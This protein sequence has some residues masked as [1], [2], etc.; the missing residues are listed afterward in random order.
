M[1]YLHQGLFCQRNKRIKLLPGTRNNAI[2]GEWLFKGNFS[3][4]S[5][6]AFNPDYKLTVGD[7]ILLQLWGAADFQGEVTIDAHGNI[8]IPKVGPVKVQGVNNGDLNMV[9]KKAVKRVYKA[10]VEVYANLITSQKIK[11]FVSG[12]VEN[13]GLYEGH[14]ADSL[15]RFIDQAGGI[16]KD[17]GSYRN[18]EL[19]RHGKLINQVDLY[20][21]LNQGNLPYNQLQDGDVIFVHPKQAE[22]TIDGEVGFTGRYELAPNSEETEQLADILRVLSLKENATHVTV[23]YQKGS[24]ANA[25]QYAIQQLNEIAVIPG[26]SIKVSSQLKANSISVSVLGEHNSQTEMVIPWG[27]TL[28]ELLAQ[29]EYTSLSDKTAIQLFRKSVADRQKAML[30]KSLNALEQTVLTARSQTNEAA[31]LRAKEAETILSWITKARDIAP[32]GQV[33]LNDGNSNAT[34]IY[35]KQGDKIVIPAKRNLVM[36]HGEVLFPTAIAYQQNI[37][38]EQLIEQAGGALKEEDEINVII[39]HPN[40]RVINVNEKLGEKG[41]ITA[42]DEVFVLTKPD[43]KSFQLTKDIT[44][45]IYQ[46]AASAAVLL[47]I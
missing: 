25:E 17:I 11:V 10:N 3:Q 38:T 29:V 28:D 5:F 36:V 15:L 24:Q 7:N 4:H 32:K 37:T 18:I 30:D 9:V 16:R 13:P 20:Q 46:I 1:P 35:L 39:V 12:T 27:S 33:L 40:G 42:G 44:Q 31:Q 23:I 8:F 41:L 45:V 34:P 19:K 6:S 14:S 2:Y 47:A 22:V 21:F 43:E 26:S